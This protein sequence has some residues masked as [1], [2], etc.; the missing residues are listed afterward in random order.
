MIEVFSMNTEFT[1]LN[2]ISDKLDEVY[3]KNAD[4]MKTAA[5]RFAACTMD[6]HIIHTFGTG[7]SCMMGI[8]LFSRAGG[9]ANINAIMDPDTMTAY[10]SRRSGEMERISGIADIIYD[11]SNIHAGDIMVISSNSGRNAMPIEMALRCKKEGVYTICITSMEMSKDVK[12]RHE[13]GKRLFEICDL[14]LDNC[15]PV[16]DFAMTIDGIETGPVSSITSLA[17]LDTIVTE[18]VKLMKEKGFTPYVFQSQNS[19]KADNVKAYLH[20]YQRIKNL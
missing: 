2:I 16:G 17:I 5:E 4:N 19:D 18:S 7:H 14:V 11:N 8:E 13:S 6:D 3:R 15:S 1:Y 9:L 10:G 12:S 20:Y